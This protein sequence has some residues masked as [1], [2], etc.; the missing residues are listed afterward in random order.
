M[1][2]LG[3]ELKRNTQ[4]PKSKIFSKNYFLFRILKKK[5]KRGKMKGKISVNV[6]LKESATRASNRN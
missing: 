2:L 6:N 1:H 3:L 4:I 5:K